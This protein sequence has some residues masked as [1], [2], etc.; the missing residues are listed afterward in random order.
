M[1]KERLLIAVFFLLAVGAA[2]CAQQQMGVTVKETQMRAT[3]TYLGKI[4]GLLKYGDRVTVL[5]QPD[6]PK[7]WLKVKSPDGKLQGW[8]NVSALTDKPVALKAGSEQVSQ[9]ASTGDVALAGK[10]FNADVEAQYKEQENLDY[11][12]VDKMERY[13]AAPERI[14]AFIAAGGLV[15]QGGAQ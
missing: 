2:F 13:S 10:G 14:A 7:G 11:T 5:D 12:W 4:V 1:R 6:A 9:Q 15:E 3:P 8:V